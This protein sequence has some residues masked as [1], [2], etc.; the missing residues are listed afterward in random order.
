MLDDPVQIRV[1]Q[2]KYLVEPMHEFDVGVA[3]HLAEDSRALDCL[4]GYRIE[5][6]EENRSFDFRHS[7]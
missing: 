7:S 5:F 1:G 4:V 3:P 6:P 2:L